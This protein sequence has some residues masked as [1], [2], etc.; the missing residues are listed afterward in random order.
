[1][2][3]VDAVGAAAPGA[4]RLYRNQDSQDAGQ[5]SRQPARPRVQETLLI[6]QFAGTVR[7]RCCCRSDPAVAGARGG[8]ERASA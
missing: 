2:I 7:T 4:L 1:V 6:A 8:F 5:A 3:L